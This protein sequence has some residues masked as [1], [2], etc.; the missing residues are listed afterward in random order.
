MGDITTIGFDI[1][2]NVF[3]AHAVDEASSV[4][5]RIGI[6]TLSWNKRRGDGKLGPKIRDGILD[7]AD[8]LG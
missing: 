3:Q 7:D 2:K 8:A 5:V 4:V 1:A 6:S